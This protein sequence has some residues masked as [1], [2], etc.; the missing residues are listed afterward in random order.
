VEF[1][2]SGVPGCIF[3]LGR[4]TAIRRP[5]IAYFALT[6]LCI[7]NSDCACLA[8]SKQ[9]TP[10]NHEQSKGLYDQLCLRCH[11][12]NGK[13]DPGWKTAPDF[14]R[15]SWQDEV[16]DARLIISILEGKGTEMPG[17][18]RQLNKPKAKALVAY[19]RAFAP[20]RMQPAAE[21]A[22]SNDLDNRMQQ[23]RGELRDLQTQQKELAASTRKSDPPSPIKEPTLPPTPAN[24]R[25]VITHPKE[26]PAGKQAPQ[27]AV[28]VSAP[29]TIPKAVG[30]STTG[31]G[32]N[33]SNELEMPRR[34]AEDDD[35]EEDV[36]DQ[37]GLQHLL[38]WLGRF[39]SA[40]VHLPLGLLLSA[41]AAEFLFFATARR[42][43]GTTSRGC[44]WFAGLTAPVAAALGWFLAGGQ[45]TDH[46]WV[47]TLHRWMGTMIALCALFALVLI[48]VSCRRWPLAR[49]TYRLTL[50]FS[51]SLALATGFFGGALIHGLN[52]Y[53]WPL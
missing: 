53:A 41:A 39:H 21:G 1:S 26:T 12:A 31:I 35:R 42:E 22:S 34:Q 23:L 48:E 16:D 24:E 14:T 15:R 18:S 13:G 7:S 32:P 49:G 20:T 19:I 40:A 11:A 30:G 51:V 29:S 8:Q 44:V 38:R 33:K 27:L 5:V 28:D 37:C 4:F 43:F 50:I 6:L 9:S 10:A 25:P 17:F 45:L 3:W 2:P 46:N 52:Y 47:L 36:P